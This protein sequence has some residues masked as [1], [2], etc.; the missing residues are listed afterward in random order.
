MLYRILDDIEM[1]KKHGKLID[2]VAGNKSAVTGVRNKIPSTVRLNGGEGFVMLTEPWMEYVR[3]INNTVEARKYQFKDWKD[4]CTIL[5]D[6]VGWHN[7]GKGNRVEQVTFSGNY[8]NVTRVE[9]N[10]AYVDTYNVKDS[11]PKVV[12]PVGVGIMFAHPIVHLLST[13]FSNKLDMTTN[14]KY[15]RIFLIA[16]EGEE[17]WMDIRC[18]E[19][20]GEEP[21]NLY[22][23]P[24][25]TVTVTPT[26]QLVLDMYKN[27]TDQEIIEFYNFHHRTAND[28]AA[29]L[30]R[31]LK[32]R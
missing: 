3:K 11:P 25:P 18:L 22:L 26:S 7:T 23:D 13:Q 6:A 8:V 9:G 2:R 27:M 24:A 20:V 19:K 16:N 14:Q 31:R 10:K 21:D 30:I 12:P 28:A 5:K 15:P 1:L 29:E 32:E 17:L 4:G